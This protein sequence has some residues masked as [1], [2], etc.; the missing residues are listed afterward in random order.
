M[1]TSAIRKAITTD[2]QAIYR[3][4]R[5]YIIEHEADQLARWDV[6][7]E[8]IRQGLMDNLGNMV[9]SESEGSITGL[10]YW[11]MHEGTP[12]IYSIYVDGNYRR[13]GIASKLMQAIEK[14]VID[15]HYTRLSLST[16]INNPAQYLFESF[17]YNEI[18]RE[19]G[20]IYYLK[21][22]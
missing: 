13:Q 16:L 2:L 7:K 6:A 5:A 14:E 12:C 22:F 17:D 9:V 15:Q 8:R 11:S 18:R 10:C 19:N 4:E 1:K 3:L 20:W 21:I